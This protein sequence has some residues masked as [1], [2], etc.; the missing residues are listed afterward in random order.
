[1]GQLQPSPRDQLAMIPVGIAGPDFAN[2]TRPGTN[3]F[4]NSIVA[5]DAVTGHLKW[6]HH[7]SGRR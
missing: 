5:L 7:L 3:L 4:T 6:W 1:M 2:E